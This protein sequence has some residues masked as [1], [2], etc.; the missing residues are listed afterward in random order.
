VGKAWA[1]RTQTKVTKTLWY[2]LG[3]AH[4]FERKPLQ[5]SKSF[6]TSVFA[7]HQAQLSIIFIWAS[8]PLL[9]VAWQG[10]FEQWSA[11]PAVIPVAHSIRDPHFGTSAVS[12]FSA[13]I[14]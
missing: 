5:S 6:T 3:T 9:Q 7:A 11:N 1:P 4:D 13:Q 10:N 8:I 12:A 2:T 14:I